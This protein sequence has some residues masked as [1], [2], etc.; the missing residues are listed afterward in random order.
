[1]HGDSAL[2]HNAARGSC[3]D[4]ALLNLVLRGKHL[5]RA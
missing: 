1:M 5:P 3:F 2:E 4:D